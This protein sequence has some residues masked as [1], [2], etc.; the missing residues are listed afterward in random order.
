MLLLHWPTVI[1]SRLMYYSLARLLGLQ[2][3]VP[4]FCRG[5]DSGA[6]AIKKQ[7]EVACRLFLFGLAICNRILTPS[8]TTP[9]RIHARTTYTHVLMRGC[10]I[11]EECMPHLFSF[12][13]PGSTSGNTCLVPGRKHQGHAYRWACYTVRYAWHVLTFISAEQDAHFRGK[14]LELRQ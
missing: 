10:Q 6:H 9:I 11:P 1:V 5:V 14:R 8:I 7:N 13:I 4:L 3:H 12:K 2:T